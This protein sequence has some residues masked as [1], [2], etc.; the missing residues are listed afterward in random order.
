LSGY[1]ND[2]DGEY[3]SILGG[4]KSDTTHSGS[5]VAGAYIFSSGLYTVDY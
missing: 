2:A 4:F 5:A 3:S 1:D